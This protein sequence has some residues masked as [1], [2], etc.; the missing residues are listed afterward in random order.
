MLIVIVAAILVV[1]DK[2]PCAP[3]A[4]LIIVSTGPAFL[5]VVAHKPCKL[6]NR[7]QEMLT[8]ST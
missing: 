8:L 6:L 3:L 1:Y 4:N 5:L 7:E 2:Q